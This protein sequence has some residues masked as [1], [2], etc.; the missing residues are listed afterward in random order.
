[1]ELFS[2]LV[3]ISSMS[4]SERIKWLF[5]AFDSGGSKEL[6][7]DEMLLSIKGILNG[8]AR[9]YKKDPKSEEE[10][11]NFKPTKGMFVCVCVFSKKVV[12]TLQCFIFIKH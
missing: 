5:E 10:I 8:F 11:L 1:M 3:F 9:V 2:G 6:D 4:L 12:I 7:Q